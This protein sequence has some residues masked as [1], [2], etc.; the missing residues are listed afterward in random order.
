MTVND[1]L[2][3][4]EFEHNKSELARILV[5]SRVTLSIYNEDIDGK[6]HDIKC[7]DGYYELFTNQTNKVKACPK[8]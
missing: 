7:T 6:H 5:V 1:L 4:D 3:T 8:K 2:K